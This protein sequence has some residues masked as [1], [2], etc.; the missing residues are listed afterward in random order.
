MSSPSDP[1]DNGQHWQGVP[2]NP[3]WSRPTE[4]DPPST[5]L[6][7][8]SVTDTSD[9]QYRGNPQHIPSAPVLHLAQPSAPS[10]SAT[11]PA[12][13]ASASNGKTRAKPAPADA[14]F[15][16]LPPSY[17]ATIIRNIPQIHD[18]YDHLR[19]PAGQRGVDIKTRIPLDSTPAE[20]YQSGGGSGGGS[21]AGGS[22]ASRSYGAVSQSPHLAVLAQPSAPHL[23]Q[24]QTAAPGHQQD[25]AAYARDVDRLLGPSSAA[26]QPNDPRGQNAHHPDLDDE[27]DEPESHWSVVGEGKAWMSL[28]YMIVILLPWS[29]FC[30]VWTLLSMI[31]ALITMIVPPVGYVFVVAAVTSWRALARADLE[32]SKMLVPHSVRNKHPYRT[33]SVFVSLHSDTEATSP[34]GSSGSGGRH[35]PPRRRSKNVWDKGSNHLGETI[36]SGHTLKSLSYFLIWK[37]LF[38]IPVFCILVVFGALTIPFMFCLLPTLLHISRTFARW[39]FRWAIVWVTEKPVPIALH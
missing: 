33:A 20:H 30:F 17:E 3:A 15:D 8:P 9:A 31:I 13:T 38:A 27:D 4:L 26:S 7:S 19:G 21:G 6:A 16:D 39:Q 36:R 18:N 22:S 2:S 37:V 24:N 1:F 11:T 32:I 23:L 35:S 5:S 34:P 14:S 28:T 25:D 10:S 29:L 12:A